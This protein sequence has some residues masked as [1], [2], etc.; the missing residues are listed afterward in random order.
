MRYIEP[1]RWPQMLGFYLAL[2]LLAG[3]GVA[4]WLGQRSLGRPGLGT[5]T[6]INLL[7]PLGAVGL[8]FA[9]P[10]RRVAAGGGVLLTAGYVLGTAFRSDP[11]FWLWTPA[12][13]PQITHPVQLP[14][15]LAYVLIGVGVAW[16]VRGWRRVGLADAHLRCRA[17]GYLLVG[18]PGPRCPECGWPCEPG[19]LDG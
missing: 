19:G 5:A 4:Q 10:S 18:V 7:L 1:G 3:S 11:R 6:A 12:M 16:A 13:L 15:T 9:Y 8:A 14:A 17:C 2:G